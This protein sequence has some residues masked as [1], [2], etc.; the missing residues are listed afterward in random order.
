MAEQVQVQR[1]AVK[2]ISEAVAEQETA[3]HAA[4][5]R[6]ARRAAKRA[7]RSTSTARLLLVEIANALEG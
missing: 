4:I 3:E 7:A 5:L 2:R 1:K 6:N